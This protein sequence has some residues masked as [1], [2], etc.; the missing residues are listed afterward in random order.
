MCERL[1]NFSFFGLT[2]VNKGDEL[3]LG[4][5]PL[6]FLV[7]KVEGGEG[8]GKHEVVDVV[9]H[10]VFEGE[11]AVGAY[12]EG[13]EDDVRIIAVEWRVQSGDALGVAH[14]ERSGR[15]EQL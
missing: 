5:T 9:G 2:V 12:V 15:G 6:L 7:E 8:V 10:E 1:F 13:M 14:G 4:E 11:I 3:V